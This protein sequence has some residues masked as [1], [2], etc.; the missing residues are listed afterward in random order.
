MGA[1]AHMEMPFFLKRTIS[2]EIIPVPT[3]QSY[4]AEPGILRLTST[5][6]KQFIE[7]NTGNVQADD[8]PD[9]VDPSVER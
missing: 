7:S 4:N 2:A 3:T 6:L 5:D 8:L 1:A 9:V